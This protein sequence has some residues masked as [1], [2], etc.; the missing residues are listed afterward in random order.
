LS[1]PGVSRVTGFPEF[2]NTWWWANGLL[3]A[4]KWTLKR[5]KIKRLSAFVCE[6]LMGCGRGGCRAGSVRGLRWSSSG[7]GH[8][9]NDVGM[10]WLTTVNQRPENSLKRVSGELLYRDYRFFCLFF[11]FY[12][13]IRLISNFTKL[14]YYQ[15]ITWR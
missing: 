3:C 12:K 15:H 4:H 6:V 8:N 1:N 11:Y 14:Y 7:G 2:P 10:T 9:V 5:G 13:N